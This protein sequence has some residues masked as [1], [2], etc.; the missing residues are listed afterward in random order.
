MQQEA[1]PILLVANG[2]RHAVLSRVKATTPRQI[3]I[4]RGLS[5]HSLHFLPQEGRGGLPR[6]AADAP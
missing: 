3:C 6:Y 2:I 1:F 5:E 4:A